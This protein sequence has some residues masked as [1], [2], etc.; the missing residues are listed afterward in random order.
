VRNCILHNSG[1]LDGD[2]HEGELR[3]DLGNGQGIEGI[4]VS[5]HRPIGDYIEIKKGVIE[6]ITMRWRDI[7]YDI[8]KI[9]SERGLVQR[10]TRLSGDG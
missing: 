8:Y 10:R 9:S 1:L 2:E 5:N 4:I 3:T 6:S 7:M